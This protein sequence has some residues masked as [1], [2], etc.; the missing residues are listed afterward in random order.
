MLRRR[1]ILI[2]AVVLAAAAFIAGMLLLRRGQA[3]EAARLLPSADA[4]LYV[5]LTPLRTAGLFK[6]APSNMD[7]DYAQFVRDTGF[8]FERDLDEA[9]FAIHLPPAAI[10][11]N[12]TTPETR[13]SEV[14]VGRFDGS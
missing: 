6:N 11:A 4:Y 3:P 12:G 1:N 2:V 14:F 5:D 8:Q 10:A 9:G 13:Y 7:P